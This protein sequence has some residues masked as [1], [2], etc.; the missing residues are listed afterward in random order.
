MIQSLKSSLSKG[1]LPFI[2]SCTFLFLYVPIFVLALYSF[3]SKGFPS[4]W[5]SF[6]LDWY[7]ELFTAHELWGAF[8]TSVIIA[9]V[10]TTFSLL[11]GALLIYYKSCGGKTERVLPLFYGNLVIPETLLAV[12]LISYFTLLNIP[13]GM[14]TLIVGHTVL[15]IGFVVPILFVRY[16]DLDPKLHE[17]S[18]MLGASPFRTF[19]KI[20]LPLL[21][22]TMIASGLLIFV[23]SFDDFVVSYFCS[24][25]SVQTLS[26][27]LISSIRYGISPVVN[28][29]STLMLIVTS[30]LVVIFFSPKIRT[31]VF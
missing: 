14:T 26:L 6:T 30:A 25:T 22:P 10:S 18:M 31:K 23:I 15:G 7:K 11:M 20:T 9:T 24:G 12:S 27:Y 19:Y 1:A 28:A 3:N 4:S 29:L 16:N 2:V 21:R 8:S 5:D 13:L 17:A